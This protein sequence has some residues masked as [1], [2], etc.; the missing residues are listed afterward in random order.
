[1]WFIPG[2]NHGAIHEHIIVKE[3]SHTIEALHIADSEITS[4]AGKFSKVSMLY[5]YL[6]DVNISPHR[7]AFGLRWP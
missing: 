3:G 1:M 2:S 4:L 7:H 6:S 5:V